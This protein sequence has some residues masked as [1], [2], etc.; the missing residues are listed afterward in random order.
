[1]LALEKPQLKFEPKIDNGP[2]PFKPC[3]KSK[4][5]ATKPLDI[6]LEQDEKGIDW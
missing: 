1:M 2:S 3:L 4:P 6:Y 5:N